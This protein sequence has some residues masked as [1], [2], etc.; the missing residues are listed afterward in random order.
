MSTEVHSETEL[1]RVES[2][3]ARKLVEESTRPRVHRLAPS[4]IAPFCSHWTVPW[5]EFP[6]RAPEI[7]REGACDPRKSIP[8]AQSPA[9]SECHGLREFHSAIVRSE[10]C[11]DLT[12]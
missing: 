8:T 7:T 11:R 4:P 12:P 5:E 3:S 1:Y 10:R 2:R 6:A 9:R